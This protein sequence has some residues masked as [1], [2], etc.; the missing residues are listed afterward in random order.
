MSSFTYI[1]STNTY[2]LP[3]IYQALYAENEIMN[4]TGTIPTLLYDLVRELDN[5]QVKQ[6]QNK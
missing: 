1:L 4:K 5:L 6:T 2:I 3:P